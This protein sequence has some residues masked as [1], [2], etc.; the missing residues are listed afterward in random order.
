MK[1]QN[2][3]CLVV[4]RRLLSRQEIIQDVWECSSHLEET[5]HCSRVA[6]VDHRRREL[7]IEGGSKVFLKIATMKQIMWFEK[8][9]KW[10]QDIGPFRC[11]IMDW[12]NSIQL[13]SFATTGSHHSRWFPYLQVSK[14]C[15]RLYVHIRVW[16]PPSSQRPHLWGVSSRDSRAKDSNTLQ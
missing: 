4:E 11:T 10:A 3:E 14:V 16:A 1:W 6:N 12:S 8:K 15:T 9:G 5:Y 13:N 2:V 7:Q